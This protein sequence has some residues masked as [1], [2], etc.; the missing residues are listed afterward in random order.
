LAEQELLEDLLKEVLSLDL[1]E[2]EV[3]EVVVE[4]ELQRLQVRMEVVLLPS[5]WSSVEILEQTE[6]EA[7]VYWPEDEEKR[8]EDQV[9][10]LTESG[11][12]VLLFYQEYSEVRLLDVTSESVE[13]VMEGE[14]EC[15][16]SFSVCV[17]PS[18]PREHEARNARTNFP[19]RQTSLPDQWLPLR[20]WLGPDLQI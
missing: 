5:L 20:D 1:E 13:A 12:R 11:W 18:S 19:A 8:E 3:L 2:G 7:E 6:E 10:V 15:D 14:A 16:L 4:V 17:F 9:S